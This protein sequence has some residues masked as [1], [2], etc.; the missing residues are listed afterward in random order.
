VVVSVM[1]SRT[2]GWWLLAAAVV[3][4]AAAA[5]SGEAERAAEQH[6]ERISGYLSQDRFF[7]SFFF[8]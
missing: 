6:S 3:L 7:L 2:V 5:D 4:A 1:G 8:T